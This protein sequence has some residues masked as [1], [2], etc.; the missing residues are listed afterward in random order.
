M[1]LFIESTEVAN[2]VDLAAIGLVRI[3]VHPTILTPSLYV[4]E[5]FLL[6]AQLQVDWIECNVM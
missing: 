4:L 2:C 1:A 3:F 5:T 6:M